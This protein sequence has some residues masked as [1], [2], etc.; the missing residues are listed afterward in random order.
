MGASLEGSAKGVLKFLGNGLRVVARCISKV[1]RRRF[2]VAEIH[3][4][5]MTLKERFGHRSWSEW[6]EPYR[7]YGKL[8]K[9]P[10]TETGAGLAHAF[11][12]FK[13]FQQWSA[14]KTYA[15]QRGVSIFGDLPIFVAM[16]SADVWTHPFL[17]Q[18]DAELQP[19][20]VAGVPPDYFAAGGQ[21]WGNPLYAWERHVIDDYAWW[22]ARLEKSFEL[23]DVVRIDHFRG[24]DQYCRIPPKA[25]N[26][27]EYTWE[28]GPGLRFFETVRRRFPDAKLVA[29]DLGM[30]T[31]SVRRLVHEAG[32]PGM[33]VLQFGF[34][35]ATEYLPH[36][37][38]PYSVLYPGTH[39]NDTS[40]GWFKNQPD[41][42]KQ[43]LAE[44]LRT[45]AKDVSWEMIHAGYAS[46]SRI[47][48]APLQDFLGLG[49]EA[50]M[51]TPGQA[52]GNWRWRFTSQQFDRLWAE[53]AQPLRDLARLYQR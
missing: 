28:P 23:Y 49:S 24:F 53:Q 32:L 2:G 29:E 43:Y 46:A 50:R 41:P 34:E 20:G 1:S 21:R 44:Y 13:F 7:N 8:I 22:C 5:F 14:L 45:D 27:S 16:D 19:T 52:I 39:D 26:A 37:A 35:G 3:A 15:N 25:E 38:I 36:S 31:D 6:P 30:I 11:Y 17:F 40:W 42:V 12:Q 18:M 4:L 47:F 48:I 33:K 10:N 9:R 51:N